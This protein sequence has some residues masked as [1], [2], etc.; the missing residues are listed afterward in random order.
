MCSKSGNK[1][2]EFLVTGSVFIAGNII[3]NNLKN[4]KSCVLLLLLSPLREPF[5]SITRFLQGEFSGDC[6]I[7]I[8]DYFCQ[9]NNK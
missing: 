4:E 2:L 8:A 5:G 7:A 6:S 9:A 1:I 3:L